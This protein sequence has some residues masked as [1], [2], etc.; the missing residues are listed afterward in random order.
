MI[1]RIQYM[2]DLGDGTRLFTDKFDPSKGPIIEIS[3][4]VLDDNKIVMTKNYKVKEE[5]EQ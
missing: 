4:T 3:I 5:N 2:Y 1:T